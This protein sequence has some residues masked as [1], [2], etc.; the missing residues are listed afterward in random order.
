MRGAGEEENFQKF[1]MGTFL[2]KG[3]NVR[4]KEII[5]SV[6]FEEKR[7]MELLLSELGEKI[8]RE[9]ARDKKVR[10][11]D[12]VMLLKWGKE[13]KAAVAENPQHLVVQLRNL[14][15]EVE[16]ILLVNDS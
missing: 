13:L 8:G 3:W 15:K 12:S 4:V 2:I 10:K 1:L 16:K 6:P 14:H 11:I 7:E 5:Q 9:W